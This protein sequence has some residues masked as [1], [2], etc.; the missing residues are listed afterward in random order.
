MTQ[1]KSRQ[2]IPKAYDPK[3]VEQRIYERWVEGGYFTPKIDRSKKPYVIIMPPPNVTGE[4]HMGHALTKALQ[5]EAGEVRKWA[6]LALGCIDPEPKATVYSL[7]KA[8]QDKDSAVR[9]SAA[10]AL[11]GAA[12]PDLV[13]RLQD[14]DAQVRVDAAWTVRQ[15]GSPAKDAVPA[16]TAAALR[17]NDTRVRDEMAWALVSIGRDAV[18]ALRKALQDE[19]SD[20]RRSAALVLGR[21]GPSAK[22]ALPALIKALQDEASDVRW[23]ARAAWALLQIDPR[24]EDAVAALRKALQGM[25]RCPQC[26]WSYRW[27]GSKCFHCQYAF[28]KIL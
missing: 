17:D 21:I 20:V 25:G 6:A 28:G 11:G 12:V 26:G 5:D 22:D 10:L 8:L 16:L 2:E 19:A 24:S 15:I 18:P 7:R 3:A 13:K 27:D 4:L 14:K 23:S 9:R 1:T